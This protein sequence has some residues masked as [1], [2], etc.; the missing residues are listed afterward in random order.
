MID[1]PKRPPAGAAW[2]RMVPTTRQQTATARDKR[3]L[4]PAWLFN[5]IRADKRTGF[6]ISITEINALQ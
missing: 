3:R 5:A 4:P 2:L 6:N 1:V